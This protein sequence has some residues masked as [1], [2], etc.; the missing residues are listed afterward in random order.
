MDVFRFMELSIVKTNRRD[1]NKL[2]PI[3]ERVGICVLPVMRLFS[4]GE[5]LGYGSSSEYSPSIFK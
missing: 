2:I 3:E 4:L 1:S 5:H